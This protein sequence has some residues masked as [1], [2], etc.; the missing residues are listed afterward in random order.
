MSN[1]STITAFLQGKGLSPAAIAGIEGNLQVESGFDPTNH[2]GDGGTSWG[3]AQWHLSRQQALVNYA[4]AQGTPWSN[5]N[6]QLN[7]LWNDLTSN[8][9]G[10]L[11]TLKTPGITPGA[12]ATAFSQQYEVNAGGA[13]PR[14]AAANKIA[15]GGS[16]YFG[17]G[18][19]NAL[20]APGDAIKS[21]LGG[22]GSAASDVVSGIKNTEDATV[23]V[24]KAAVSTAEWVSNP[25]NWL[26]VAQVVGG[27]ML[28]IL[29]AYIAF[30]DTGAGK[31]ASDAGKAAANAVPQVKAAKIGRAT[32]QGLK[33]SDAATNAKIKYRG[34]NPAPKAP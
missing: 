2:S 20:S 3:I 16:S 17:S 12:A 34:T 11:N 10:L 27:G 31:A 26:R 28:V 13:A 6:T 33:A 22:A 30:K 15:G 1:Q 25:H 9:G 32:T 18:L 14:V 5:L 23:A 24:G 4:A 21:V 29:G 7:Y 19:I 8:Y